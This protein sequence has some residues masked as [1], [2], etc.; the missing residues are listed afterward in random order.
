MESRLAFVENGIFCGIEN[1]ICVT[2][3]IM[4]EQRTINNK[5]LSSQLLPFALSLGIFMI[6]AVFGWFKLRYGFNFIDE[7]YHMTEAW[8]LTVGDNFFS[9]KFT[10]ALTL[11]AF[12]NA[13]VFKLYP[14]ITLLGF[15]ELQFTLTIISLLLLSF[16]LYKVSKDFW[17]QP[18]IFSIFA[19]TGLDPV[20]MISNLY[21]QTYPHLFITLY[22]AFFIIGLH[23]QSALLKRILYITAGVFLW[24]ISFSL[25]HMSLV[26]IS[27]FLLFIFIKIFKFESLDFNFKDLCFVM[28][29]VLLLWVVFVGIYGNA[30]IQNVITSV[31]TALSE[32][33]HAPGALITFNWEALKHIIITLFFMIAFLWSTKLS[34]TPLL[35]GIL[36]MLSVIMFAAIDTSLFGLITPY[37]KGWFDRPMW[38]AA[39][40]VSSYFLFLCNFIFK[41]IKKKPWNNFELFALVLFIP[42]IIAAINSSVF[43]AMGFL[44]VLHSSIPAVAAMACTILSME[45]IK[46]RVYLV[47]LVI[48]ILLFAPFYY[49]TAWADW[50]FTYFDVAPEQANVEIETG[51]GKGIKTNHIYKD[52]YGWISTTSEA[53][54]DKDDYVISYIFSPMVHMI[55][56]RRPALDDS[57]ISLSLSYDYYHKAIERMKN[58]GRKLQLAYVFEAMP[59]LQPVTLE[60]PARKWYP[61]E[62][63]FPSGDPISQ[64][65]LDNMT[66]IE[67]FPISNK[68]SVRLFLD[69]ASA[70]F[71]LENKLKTDPAN[72]ELNLLVGNIYQKKG[73]FDKAKRYYKKAASLH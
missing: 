38:F 13:F 1:K 52:L 23:Q 3:I 40:L 35:V 72:P 36:S 51:F 56:L 34:N 11:T 65:V 25:L 55:T 49:A 16:A 30:F 4:K 50:K 20:G 71:I 5:I 29:P 6:A 28:A 24:L 32:P 8:R 43:S 69:N 64:Y 39:L 60:D 41:I 59:A 63:T 22:L 66:P 70:L 62:Y 58:R 17:F 67:R 26:I 15:R 18:L 46:K 73:D 54:S 19:F 14:G 44:S 27:V 33:T 9:D 21:Y 31:Q 68:L 61:K 57:F 53:Y 7:G 48:L 2:D 42:S 47:K 45:T 37:W 10:G 12:L